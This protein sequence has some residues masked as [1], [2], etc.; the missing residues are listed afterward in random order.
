MTN[1]SKRCDTSRSGEQRAVDEQAIDAGESSVGVH[2]SVVRSDN[3]N[4]AWTGTTGHYDWM[5]H[6]PLFHHRD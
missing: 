4:W 2:S 6:A 1:F 5:D 3:V